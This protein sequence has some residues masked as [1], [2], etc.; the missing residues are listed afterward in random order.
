M[1]YDFDKVIDREGTLSYKWDARD[2][3]FPENPQALP[4]W[5]ADMDFPC[6][7]PIAEAVRKRAAHPIYGYSKVADD[8]MTLSAGCQ[9]KG[10]H[11]YGMR[12][13][14]EFTN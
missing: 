8:A 4:F 11:C 9:K 12:G 3:N 10:N 7:E 14:I 1:K 2:I 6:P 5:I 13:W